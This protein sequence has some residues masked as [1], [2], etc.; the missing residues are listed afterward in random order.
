MKSEMSAYDSK[1]EKL[2]LDTLNTDI[3]LERFLEVKVLNIIHNIH[4]SSIS[5]YGD[6]KEFLTN[7]NNK[8]KELE[9]KIEADCL[10]DKKA[11]A[12]RFPLKKSSKLDKNYYYIPSIEIPETLSY[13]E[14]QENDG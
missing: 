10:I 5:N 2:K 4:E 12:E 13:D 3:Y 14:E 11:G 1:I 6:K 9:K 8:F 7:L